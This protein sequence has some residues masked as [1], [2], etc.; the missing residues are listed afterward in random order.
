MANNELAIRFTETKYA[1][2]SEV[3]KELKMSIIDSIW[4][5]IL[6]YRSGFNRY[7]TIKSIEKNQLVVCFCP[8]ISALVN[9]ADMKLIRLMREYSLINVHNG[10]LNRFED[11]CLIT[12]LTHLANKNEIDAS[13]SYLR[14]LI[15]GD[16]RD[17]APSTRLLPRYLNA[18]N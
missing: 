1:T 12:G 2:R 16:I 9:S 14:S 4:S 17:A 8:S 7:L 11:T 18:L 13:E 5:G 10:D 6:S 15:H 3:G